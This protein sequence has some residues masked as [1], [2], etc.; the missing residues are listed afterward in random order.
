MIITYQVFN[1]LDSSDIVKVTLPWSYKRAAKGFYSKLWSDLK[2]SCAKGIDKKHIRA[3][4]STDT[5][6]RTD[7]M[8]FCFASGA[9]FNAPFDLNETDFKIINLHLDAL[10]LAYS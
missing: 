2:T 10:N 6:V 7:R 1:S 3:K 5:K 9:K 4:I 8:E